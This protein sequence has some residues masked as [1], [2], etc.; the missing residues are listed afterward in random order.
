MSKITFNKTPGTYWPSMKQLLCLPLIAAV[1]MTV[2]A[3]EVSLQSQK[4]SSDDFIKAFTGGGSST[5]A[6]APAPTSDNKVRFRGISLKK[7]TPKPVEQPKPAVEEQASFD[8]QVAANQAASACMV[9]KKSVAV[10]INFRPN[11]TNVTDTDLIRNIAQAMNS[12]QLSG[13]YFI[14]EGH[15]D[16]VGNDYYNLWLSQKRAGQVKEYLSQFNVPAD[17]LVVVGKGEDELLNAG[18]PNAAENRRVVFK[19]INGI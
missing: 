17:R 4:P 7:S 19:V 15:T 12:S 13:C 1:S 3:G 18:V 2:N 10:N 9:E 6:V 5:T 11:S 16:A 14:I 8:Q